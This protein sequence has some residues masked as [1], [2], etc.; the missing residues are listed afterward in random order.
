[1]YGAGEDSLFLKSCFDHGLRVYGS[2]VVLGACAKDISSWFQGCNEKYFY[3]KG[4]LIGIMFPRLHHV[5][6]VYFSLR[7][8][9][10]TE[11]SVAERL[12][13]MLRG[14]RGGRSLVPYPG[15]YGE[16]ET[17]AL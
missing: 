4:A 5:L 6:A 1:M 3:D 10:E 14:I 8:K 7:F 16:R 11:L 13:W 9:R 17:Q 15:D 12:H 2:N